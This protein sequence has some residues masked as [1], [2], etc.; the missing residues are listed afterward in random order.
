MTYR[1]LAALPM[2][3][4][5]VAL[6]AQAP[7]SAT[8][9]LK[10]VVRKTVLTFNP[11]AIVAGYFGGDV[12]TAVSSTTTFGVG[13]SYAGFDN[14]NDYGALEAKVRYYPQERALYGFSVAGNLGMATYREDG[15]Y[16]V[17]DANGNPVYSGGA[18][19]TRR[20]R[21]TVGT[22][23]SYQWLLGPKRR[24]VTVVGVGVKRFF[25]AEDYSSPFDANVIP[26]ARINIGFAF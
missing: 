12:E 3:C 24:F 14:F 17:Y 9:A 11:I 8:P 22:E 10:P 20:T 25:G 15:P 21:A 7:D 19:G 6:G 4:W 18:T 26:T 2:L 1:T 16:Y 5:A 23:L 13:A